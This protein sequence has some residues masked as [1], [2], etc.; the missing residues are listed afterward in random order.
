MSEIRTASGTFIP[1]IGVGTFPLQGNA[2]KNIIEEAIRIGYRLIDT[3]DD[4]RGESGIGLGCLNSIKQGVVQ[5]EDLFIQS[6]ISDNN[7]Y[8]DDPLAGVFFNR[9]SSFMKRH[10]VEDIVRY[11]VEISLRELKTDYLDSLLIHA[12]LP[13]YNEEI[14]NAMI[15]LK[16]EGK[17]RYIGV[18]NFQNGTISQMSEA[19]EGEYPHINEIY[20]SPL[21]TK[22]GQLDFAQQ[23]R[24]V[25]MTYS[26]LMDIASG[27]LKE[28]NFL[29]L[30]NKYNKSL[31]QIVLRWNIDRGCIP[32]PKTS[33]IKRLSENFNILDFSLTHDEIAYISSMNKDY[34]YLVESRLSPGF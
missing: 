23:K 33:N 29:S 24:M 11:K 16:N 30:M 20:I 1:P 22:Q 5:R 10:S 17:V 32:L 4:Y 34:Q 21:G 15:I 31:A 27:R 14:W 8:N 19:C 7:A 3:A 6:K 18:S 12:P 2:L 28:H 9:N 26:P 13:G 25:L